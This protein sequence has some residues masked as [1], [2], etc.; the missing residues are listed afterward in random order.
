M[1]MTE[2]LSSEAWVH[3]QPILVL[4]EVALITHAEHPS[5]YVRTQEAGIDRASPHLA[6]LNAPPSKQFSYLSYENRVKIGRAHV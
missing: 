3:S 1:Q 4:Y 6:P 5:M 2:L